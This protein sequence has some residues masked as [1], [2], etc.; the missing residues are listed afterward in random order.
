MSNLPWVKWFWRDWQTDAGVRTSSLAARA[1]W[2]ELLGIMHV[3]NT[4]GYLVINGKPPTAAQIAMLIGTTEDVEPLLA[5][6]ESK[7]VFSRDRR[8]VIYCRREINERKRAE[9]SAKG[10]RKGGVATRDNHWGIHAT[11]ATDRGGG[12]EQIPDS[13]TDSEPEPDS[14]P[15]ESTL[16]RSN[17]ERVNDGCRLPEGFSPDISAAVAI[18]LSAEAAATE[19]ARFVDYWHAQP[20]QRGIKTDWPAT[21]RNWCR[22]AI[23]M[24]GNTHERTHNGGEPH[25]DSSGND[26]L[27]ALARQ[28]DERSR[29]REWQ[30]HPDVRS[31]ADGDGAARTQVQDQSP[32]LAIGRR[33]G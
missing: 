27:R 21:W 16:K 2:F 5:E 26:W 29:Q 7:G 28:V 19:A 18:G 24:Q 8:G 9:A 31:D 22:R 1:L 13:D 33:T 25:R 3:G 10:G 17:R 11:R 30:A 6:L 15:A 12:R 20:G 32:P 4:G 14:A 23:D